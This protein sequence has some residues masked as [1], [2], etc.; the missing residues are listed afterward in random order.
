MEKPWVGFDSTLVIHFKNDQ[1]HMIVL[2][3]KKKLFNLSNKIYLDEDL[4]WLQVDEFKKAREQVAV[5][6]KA[7]N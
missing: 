2:W 5:V 1:E 4:T 6:C 7:N 3:S